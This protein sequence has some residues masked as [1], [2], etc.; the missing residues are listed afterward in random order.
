MK[1]AASAAIYGARAA[2]G[3]VL[4]TTKQGRTGKLDVTLDTYIGWQNVYKKPELLNAQQYVEIMNEAYA[5][6]NRTIDWANL[7]PDWNRIQSGWEGP[8]WF[9]SA[10][11]KNAFIRNHSLNISGGS[12]RS[13]FS[14]GISN[15]SQE[16]TIGKPVA[17]VYERTTVRILSLIH[18]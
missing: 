13:V 10:L 17:P 3:V 15:T 12:E 6:D 5:N 14:V 18:I 16:G 11:N 4:V 7:V 8:Q 1:D 9:E 2:N